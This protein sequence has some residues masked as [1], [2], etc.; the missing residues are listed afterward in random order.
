[1]NRILF[2]LFAGL[3]FLTSCK[4]TVTKYATNLLSTDSLPRQQFAIDITKDTLLQTAGGAWLKID[5]GT[6]TASTNKV[7]LEV[8]EAYS[9][10]QIIKAGLITQTNGQPLASGGMIYLNPAAGQNITVNKAFKIAVPA[11]YLDKRM[12][13]FKGE[14]NE[15]GNINWANPT[16]VDT[17]LQLS[18]IQKGE[19]LFQKKCVSCHGI[20][21][22]GSGPD[23]ANLYQRFGR[24]IDGEGIYLGYDHYFKKIYYPYHIS[25]YDTDSA[26]G[27]YLYDKGSIEL[28]ICNLIKLFGDTAV[29]LSYYLDKNY[30]DVENI[31][32][33]IENES[34]LKKLPLPKHSYL[35]A[36]ADSCEIY[37][38]LKNNLTKKKRDAELVRRGLIKD[39]SPLVEKR[40]DPTWQQN[41]NIPPPDFSNKVNPNEYDAV[42]YQFTI[43]SFGWYNIDMLLNKKDGVQESELFVRITGAYKEKIKIYLIIPSVK[44]YGEGGPTENNKDE[45]AFFNKNGTIPLPQNTKA[46]ILAVTETEKAIAYGLKEFNTQTKQ[47]FELSLQE[48]TIEKFYVAIKNMD[49]DKLSITAAESK[50]ATAI[51]TTDKTIK[52]LELELKNAEGLKPKRCDCDCGQ[53]PA[54]GEAIE[55]QKKTDSDY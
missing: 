49:A 30:R 15:N 48:S 40:P 1:M 2:L 16:P 24:K 3:L 10:E 22:E 50:N 18:A 53:R 36:S 19:I 43:E 11:N 52:Q 17:N 4:T 27:K 37:N 42:Y 5:K 12:Q 13:L 39:N 25:N 46:Y 32:D 33:Y 14:K 28:Y 23:L 51:K 34:K 9:M 8:K 35:N 21:K 38:I 20:G 26:K 44:V 55:N 7:I 54:I 6:F 31:Y 29:D 41:N 47:A 45:Y